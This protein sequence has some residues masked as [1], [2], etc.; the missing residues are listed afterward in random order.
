MLKL[1]D[2]ENIT[3]EM[4]S[5]VAST[6]ARESIRRMLAAA[7][8]VSAEPVGYAIQVDGEIKFFQ[9]LDQKELAEWRA[10]KEGGKVINLYSCPQPN[11]QEPVTR[12]GVVHLWRA[13]ITGWRFVDEEEY[14]T[15]KYNG[16]ET[17]ILYDAPQPSQQERIK[18]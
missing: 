3:P 1:I 10:N 6:H 12:T 17:R 8:A 14:E 4:E 9:H 18:E 7:P 15:A 13:P 5:E 16:Y 2:T 11:Q